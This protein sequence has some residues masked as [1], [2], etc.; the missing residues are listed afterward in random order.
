MMGG[1]IVALVCWMLVC[2]WCG[3]R[4]QFRWFAIALILGLALVVIWVATVLGADLLSA[5]ALMSFFSALLYASA[6]FGVGWL[7]GRFVRGWQGSKVR[8]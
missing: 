2:I 3:Y 6:S 4:A 8:D 7:A 1:F 5:N